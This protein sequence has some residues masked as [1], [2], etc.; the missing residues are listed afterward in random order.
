MNYND[1]LDKTLEVI[2]SFPN[3]FKLISSSHEEN[4]FRIDP[5]VYAHFDDQLIVQIHTDARDG[6]GL[7]W[8]DYSRGTEAE[9]RI[10]LRPVENLLHK[11]N[12]ASAI[13]MWLENAVYSDEI[14]SVTLTEVINMIAELDKIG[15]EPETVADYRKHLMTCDDSQFKQEN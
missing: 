8:M 15:G 12:M 5:N 10:L 6:Q 1:D 9:I 3:Q 11:V 4:R 2:K 14:H 13:E 7:R